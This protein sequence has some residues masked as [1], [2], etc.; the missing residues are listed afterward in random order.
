M[1]LLNAHIDKYN[2]IHVHVQFVF[3]HFCSYVKFV[4]IVFAYNN[5]FLVHCFSTSKQATGK[6]NNSEEKKVFAM[7]LL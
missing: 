2:N 7:R 5:T 3:I 1:L 6:L 4:Y